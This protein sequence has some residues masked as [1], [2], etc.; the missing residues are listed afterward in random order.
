MKVQNQADQHTSVLQ[1]ARDLVQ[2]VFA[3]STSV[4]RVMMGLNSSFYSTGVSETSRK[5]PATIT[6]AMRHRC[7]RV[8]SILVPQEALEEVLNEDESN[9]NLSLKESSFGSFCAKELEELGLPIP[10]S[11]LV[12]LSQ[13][14]F[15]SYAR[16]LWRHHRDLKG[17]KGR[18][19]L[20]IL[21]LYLKEPISDHVFF[22]SIMKAIEELNIPRT[23]ILACECLIR[24]MD[25]IGPKNALAFLQSNSMDISRITGKLLQVVSADLKRSIESFKCKES[26]NDGMEERR[27]T[28]ITLSRLSRVVG[29]FSD[30]H[31]GQTLLVEFC[32]E[33]LKCFPLV[34]KTDDERQYLR[35]SLEYAIFRTKAE[36]AQENLLGRLSKV[37]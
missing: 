9:P 13:M 6:F 8:A 32:D 18:F 27:P 28:L 4:D 36:N 16:A 35:S 14:H 12:Q 2:I 31:E 15:P 22:L 17:K 33:L 5:N 1:H 25:N 21:E 10:H 23:L 34:T 20:L 30:T 26:G 24:Y 29:G 11:D 19:L 3:K 37:N 7:L